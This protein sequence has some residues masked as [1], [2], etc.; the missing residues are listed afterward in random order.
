ME[1][2]KKFRIEKIVGKTDTAS[3]YGSGLLE[4]FATPSMIA[5]MEQSAHQLAQSFLPKE[6]D[7]VGIE[8]HI[9]HIKASPLGAKVYAESELI[10]QDG[11]ILT[12]NVIAF[13]EQGEIGRGTHL[14]YII[15]PAKFMNKI[16]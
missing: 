13:D 15:N 2:G 14:R 10:K 3:Y 6:Q 5:L 4:V 8:L 12:F 9:Q 16:S 7:T 1:I 11:K